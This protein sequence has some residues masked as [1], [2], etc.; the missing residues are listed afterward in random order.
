MDV[1]CIKRTLFSVRQRVSIY[2][3]MVISCASINFG[4]AGDSNSEKD[5]QVAAETSETNTRNNNPTFEARGLKHAPQHAA[6]EI[7]HAKIV[8]HTP[9]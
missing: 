2:I 1:A 9:Q 8:N 7:V 6:R 3:C 4:R 5:F